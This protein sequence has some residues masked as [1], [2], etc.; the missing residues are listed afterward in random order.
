[1]SSNQNGLIEPHP[2]RIDLW[3]TF[4]EEIH[5]TTLLHR[6]R[7]LLSEEESRREARFSFKKDRH[8]FLITRA[9]VRT[10]L[11]RYAPVTPERWQ[12]STT[13]YG[14][15]CIAND[16]LLTSVLSFNV[17]HTQGLIV[18]GVT[19]DMDLGID[20][21]MVRV[22][23]APLDAVNAYFSSE[24]KSAIA[25]MPPQRQQER[26]FQ[27]WTLKESYLKARG[28]GLSIPLDKFSFH[29]PAPDGVRLSTHAELNDEPSRW[30]FW[31][32]R[33]T[34]HHL[35]AVCAERYDLGIQQLVARKVIPFQQ[36]DIFN[37][38]AFRESE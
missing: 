26:F 2:T 24:E 32:L 12:F 20:A 17:S 5:D 10:V 25:L 14:K 4:P 18:L 36:E 38:T 29:F 22:R 27:Y 21:E 19:R 7:L 28:A 16:I 11:S 34:P 35:T 6:Y 8:R 30:R 15:P 33:P 23:Q 31:Q 37:C 1:M 13:P 9:L 3:F